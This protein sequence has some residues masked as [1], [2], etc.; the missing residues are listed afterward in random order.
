MSLSAKFRLGVLGSGAGSNMVAIAHAASAPDYPA[1]IALVLS[2]VANAGILNQAASLGLP[3]RHIAPGQFRT[4][5]DDAAEA[6]YIHALR[7][8]Q[9]DL[10]V[11][12]GFMRVLKGQ[13]LRAFEGRVVNVHPSLL[14]AFPGLD[15]WKQ[16]LEHGVKITGCTVHFVDQGLD[17]GAIIAQEGTPVLDSDTAETLHARIHEAEHRVYPAAIA[18]LALG[19]VALQGRRTHLR[20][21]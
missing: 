5:L 1:K 9:V 21:P 10:V 2:D 20:A 11:L 7:E 19:R 16:A 8:A 6:A 15:A 4:K 14:P 3:H 13:F 12:A 17:T 18:A